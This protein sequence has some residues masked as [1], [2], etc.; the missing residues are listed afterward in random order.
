MWKFREGNNDRDAS[1]S[2]VAVEGK[3]NPTFSLGRSAPLFPVRGF[4]DELG[5]RWCQTTGPS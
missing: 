4:S 3:T 2:L 1:G 5:M